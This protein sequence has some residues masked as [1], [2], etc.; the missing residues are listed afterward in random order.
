MEKKIASIRIKAAKDCG[1]HVLLADML[2]E[3][4]KIL[5]KREYY[6][7]GYGVVMLGDEN[8]AEKAYLISAWKKEWEGVYSYA[9][10]DLHFDR[11]LVEYVKENYE[12][13]TLVEFMQKTNGMDEILRLED[14]DCDHFV[15]YP[16]IW[17]GKDS[18]YYLHYH[19]QLSGGTAFAVFIKE[20]LEGAVEE[21]A[22]LK[23]WGRG[24]CFNTVLKDVAEILVGEGVLE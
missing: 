18:L 11:K 23:E 17:R 4:V 19:F 24:V 5:N 9:L 8:M 10:T 12:K 13:T 22:F 1:E 3:E 6:N 16:H 2:L 20:I 7:C 21:Q 15:P 14:P